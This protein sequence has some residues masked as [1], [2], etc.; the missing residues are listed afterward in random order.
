MALADND[1]DMQAIG[2]VLEH[3]NVGVI[4]RSQTDRIAHQSTPF[5][6]L[7]VTSVSCTMYA[8]CMKAASGGVSGL[9][10]L[11]CDGVL[12]DPRP[13]HGAR[14][15]ENINACIDKMRVFQQVEPRLRARVP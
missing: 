5:C 10:Q 14:F 12:T 8:T 1:V 11:P 15:R 2:Q 4:R 3:V 9:D 13:A 6:R 7:P